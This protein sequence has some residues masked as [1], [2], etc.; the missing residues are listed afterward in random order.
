ML[1]DLAF[2][3]VVPL[4]Q[5]TA[6][7]FRVV[8]HCCVLLWACCPAKVNIARVFAT[9]L[10]VVPQVEVVENATKISRKTPL[11]TNFG[12]RH[13]RLKFATT[14]A[15]QAPGSRSLPETRL[16][17]GELLSIYLG[18]GQCRLSWARL[19]G[20]VSHPWFR[21]LRCTGCVWD[22]K[23]QRSYFNSY[24]LTTRT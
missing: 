14:G 3:F 13:L 1:T 6:V 7:T 19:V 18:F 11:T 8:A 20:R 12:S 24:V 15:K 10:C 16:R 23:L 9:F 4:T 21:F 5:L 17:A 2:C 22:I